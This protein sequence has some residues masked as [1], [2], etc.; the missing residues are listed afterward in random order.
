M[1]EVKE[2][3]IP[4]AGKGLFATKDFKKFEMITGYGGTPLCDHFS[5]YILTDEHGICW[6]A[7]TEYD[8]EAD[9]GRWCNDADHNDTGFKNNST[10]SSAPI[11]GFP[12]A[13]VSITE[14][15]KGEEIF[16]G[17]GQNYWDSMIKRNKILFN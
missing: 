5:E 10:F 3:Q 2:S 11:R 7:K 14:I 1:C 6:D 12:P 15:K 16:V 13:L 17:Y 4:G 9:K 8:E